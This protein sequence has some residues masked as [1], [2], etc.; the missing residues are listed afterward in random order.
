MK[1]EKQLYQCTG[2]FVA[3]GFRKQFFIA[4]DESYLRAETK[5]YD[6]IDEYAKKMGCL[7]YS[8]EI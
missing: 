3:Q 5:L 2:H 4:S 1:K 8:V 7:K 6:L